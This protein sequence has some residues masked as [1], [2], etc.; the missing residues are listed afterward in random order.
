MKGFFGI[1]NLGNGYISNSKELFLGDYPE[2]AGFKK[3]DSDKIFLTGMHPDFPPLTL[4]E[5][6]DLT[7][8]GWCRLDNLDLLQTELGLGQSS[9]EPELILHAFK[10]WGAECVTYFI[11]DFSFVIWDHANESLF[12]SKDHLGVRPL[13]YLTNKD[14]FFFSTNITLIK[15]ALSEIL[16][17]NEIFIAKELKNF[18]Q[19]VEMTF[20][21]DIHRL[22][23]AHYLN[24]SSGK[25]IKET[26]YW[27][28]KKIDLSFCKK[29]EDYFNLLRE[30]LT[31]A[32]SCRL[33]GKNT[34]GCQL[35]GGM[36]SSAIAV[37]L[38]RLINKEDLHTYSFVLDDFTK[39]FSE[40]GI[41]EKDTQEEIIRYADLIKENHHQVKR[42]HFKDAFEE[43]QKRNEVMGGL[44]PD[45]A[46]WQDSLFKMAAE[47]QGIEVIFSGFP[48]DEGI[49][50]YGTRYF[51]EYIYER[52]IFGLFQYLVDFRRG[53]IIRIQEYFKA[54]KIG[55]TI[56]D[57][58][59]I[60]EKRNLLSPSAD[61]NQTLLDE[62][63][64]F[65]T[66]YKELLKFNIC[67]PDTTL[68][69][70]SEVS[71]AN[72]Y[73]M[74]T[75]YPLA[76]IRLLEIVYSLPIH[77]FKPKPYN[78]AVFRNVCKGILPDKVRLQKKN[79]GAYTLAFYD[80]LE[81]RKQEELKDYEVLNH[82]G[83]LISEEE[84]LKKADESKM[85]RI[86]RLNFRKEVDYIIGLNWPLGNED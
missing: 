1:I 82:T 46:I 64:K 4:D 70:E 43:F 66:S 80:Y 31:A 60:L 37:L 74:E 28:L 75:V 35:S 85:S 79:N 10:K 9:E 63:F 77:L 41:D 39:G 83:L 55:S 38:S 34:I 21:K 49:S 69:L 20:F 54:K 16:P 25:P 81:K 53:G 29:D 26:Q 68:R 8:A 67:S 33:R 3:L 72:Q 84:F 61:F 2:I 48:G 71:Y 23:P 22:K 56:L 14:L 57:Y 5:F 17:L 44:G 13:F 30:T 50:D 76:D 32:I 51:Y 19:E 40:T 45:D 86:Q 36:D 73:N 15:K 59:T 12:L 24:F 11:G 65:K 7:F 18:S 62:T 58:S 42:F 27:D 47:D 78:R 52:D 6:P